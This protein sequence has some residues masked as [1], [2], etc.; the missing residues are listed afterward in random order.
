[1]NTWWEGQPQERYWLELTDRQDLGTNLRAPLQDEAGRENWRYTLF[2]SA[3]VGDVVLH[4]H[5]G[6]SVAGIVGFSIITGKAYAEDIVWAARG[7][8]ARSKGTLPHQRPGYK[9]PLGG[10]TQFDKPV[11]LSDIRTR[12]GDL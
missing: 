6:P 8:Y 5:K 11:L 10:M 9:L 7:T 3:R 2:N 4:Y 1:M 12:R